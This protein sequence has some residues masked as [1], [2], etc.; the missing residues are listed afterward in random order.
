VNAFPAIDGDTLLVGAGAP[1]PHVKHATDE[2]VAY[3]LG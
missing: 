1:A 2:L 3:A